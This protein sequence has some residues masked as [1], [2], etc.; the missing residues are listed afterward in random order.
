MSRTQKNTGRKPS[1]LSEIVQ[2]A[3]KNKGIYIM[4]IPVLIYYILFH[5]WPMYGAIIAFKDFVPSEGIWGSHWVGF[6]HFKN[7]FGNFYFWRLIKN[8]FLISFYQLIFGFPAPI[9][10]AL[11]LN[12]V[13]T[14]WFKGTVQTV[15]YLPH[16][17]SL[18]VVVGII[19][20]FANSNGIISDLIVMMGGSRE[21]LFQSPRMFRTLYVASGIWQEIGWGTIVYLSALAGIDTAQYEAAKIDGAGRFNQLLHV[22]LP[23][24]M[25]TIIILLILQLGKLLN[26]GFEKIILM[27]NPATYETADVISSYVYRM[28]LQRFDWSFSTAVGLFNSCVNF[29][30]LIVSNKISRK[31]S[32]SSLW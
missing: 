2:E 31:V 11:L 19:K 23:G 10:L 15:T 16:F 25:P 1:L 6:D 13:K 18:V 14:R 29:V 17:I 32:D 26:V 8:T 7:F 12:E 22:T 24:I 30:L 3:V 28:G 27:Y 9:I 21:S 5:L 4:A 20:D